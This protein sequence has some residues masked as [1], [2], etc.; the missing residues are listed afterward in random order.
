MATYVGIGFSQNLDAAIAAKEAADQ[1]KRQLGQER[2]D[3]AI[4]FATVHYQ[5][6][7]FLPVLYE[8][9]QR[10]RLIGCSAAGLITHHK[11]FR[12][13]IGLIILNSDN[14]RFETGCVNHLHLQDKSFAGKSLVKSTV[15][16][17]GVQQRKIF[18]CLADGLLNN[19]TDMLAGIGAQAEGDIII[20]GA[21]AS[22][23]FQFAKTYQYYK[24][25]SFQNTAI[26]LL[27][28]GRIS[29]GVA[30]QHGWKPLGRPRFVTSAEG[31]ILRTIDNKKAIDIYHRYFEAE[32]ESMRT[33]QLGSLKTLYPLGFRLNPSGHYLIRNVLGVLDDGSFL[34]Q[35]K[36]PVGAEVHIMI[37]NP[38]T[39]L[40]ATIEAANMIREQL[41]N[42]KPRVLIVFESLLRN[43]ILRRGADQVAPVIQNVL[44]GDIP[45]LGM[46]S[47]GEFVTFKDLPPPNAF[48][49]NGNIT[50]VAI[51]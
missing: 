42:K 24:E 2:I 14:V 3:L 15:S 22:D 38:E 1:A 43:R 45:L 31:H 34:C 46:Y 16:D 8:Q 30:S 48:V 26:G 9:L 35:D 39:Q 32:A 50:I 33:P 20:T 28:G 44:G 11:T 18:L 49:Q 37:S 40:E 4:V 41:A 21:G 13:G 25:K 7:E 19:L 47:W 17:F 29:V 23:N 12:R 36:I 5:A 6:E 10:T 51:G 27:L